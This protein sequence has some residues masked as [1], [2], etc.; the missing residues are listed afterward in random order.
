MDLDRLNFLWQQGSFQSKN[1]HANNHANK[2]TACLDGKGIVRVK[3]ATH[4]VPL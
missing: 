2:G 3:H 1:N 4:N